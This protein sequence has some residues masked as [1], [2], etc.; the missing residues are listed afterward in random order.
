[1]SEGAAST[2]NTLLYDLVIRDPGQQAVKI[3]PAGA[4]GYPDNGTIACSRI[5]LT[6][7]GRAQVRDGCYTGGVDA[8]QARGWTVR[9]NEIEGFWCAAGLSEHAIHFW[10]GCRDTVIERNLLRDNA[11]GVGLGLVTSGPGR[12]YPDDPCPAV[13]GYVDD[14][15]GTIRNNMIAALDPDLFSSQAGFD[16]GICLWNACAGRVF[17][18]TVF[19]LD[20]AHTWSAIEWRFPNTFVEARNNLVNHA[21]RERDGATAAQSGNLLGAQSGWFVDAAAG[22]LHLRSTAGPAL[23]AAAPAPGVSDDFDHQPRPGGTAADIGADELIW[24]AYSFFLPVVRK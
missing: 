21:L 6:D 10:R 8:H 1:M 16:C 18:N 2:L 11:R 19:T 22:N 20:P 3:N 17:Q 13:S 24:Y 23:D 15:G 7:A 4:G 12:T 14:F 9:D 5:E